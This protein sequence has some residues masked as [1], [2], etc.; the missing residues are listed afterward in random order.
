MT[1]RRPTKAARPPRKKR[2]ETVPAAKKIPR[3]VPPWTSARFASLLEDVIALYAQRDE[4]GTAHSLLTRVEELA[5]QRRTD[6]APPVSATDHAKPERIN[7]AAARRAIEVSR[8]L[9]ANPDLG[10]EQR[11][12]GHGRIAAAAA[13]RGY[14]NGD[15]IARTARDLAKAAR[16]VRLQP[17]YEAAAVVGRLLRWAGGEKRPVEHSH[18]SHTD[19]AR[20]GVLYAQWDRDQTEA[21]PNH[22][23]RPSTWRARP[24]E[25]DARCAAILSD[26][27]TVLGFIDA[28]IVDRATSGDDTKTWPAGPEAGS[29]DIPID[30]A[31]DVVR[32]SNKLGWRV[33][34]VRVPQSAPIEELRRAREQLDREIEEWSDFVLR[35]H[36]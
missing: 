13:A 4:A 19:L 22:D 8:A 5:A 34:A 14:E 25:W 28:E 17:E 10:A 6:A 23:H 24:R 33:W 30:L 1:A 9:Q 20:L 3:T 11:A 29:A 12:E 36:M 26:T 18:P 7:A 16:R 32:A 31:A 15:R 27:M 35:K 21:P 2:D